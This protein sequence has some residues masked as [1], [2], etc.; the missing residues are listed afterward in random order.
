MHLRLTVRA[1]NLGINVRNFDVSVT[2]IAWNKD[3]TN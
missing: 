1:V 2:V 3:K